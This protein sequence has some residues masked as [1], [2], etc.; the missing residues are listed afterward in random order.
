M[1]QT[2]WWF[3]SAAV[4]TLLIFVLV[5]LWVKMNEYDVEP[6]QLV[7]EAATNEYLKDN[8][9]AP[10]SLASPDAKPT[11]KIKTGIFIQSL[12]FFNSSEV[13]LTGY[14]WQ[15]YTDGI[16]D[17]IKPEKNEVG[18]ILP[19]QVNSGSDI[20]PRE[21]YR[22][23]NGDDEVIGWYFEAT[24]KQPFDYTLYPFDHKT[25]WVRM[26]PKE[27]SQ[28]IVLVPDFES[29]KATGGYDIFGIEENIVLGTWV[30][31]NTYFDYKLSSY[32]TD[33]GIADYIG[34]V[35]FPELHYN[36][37]VKRKFENAFIVYLLPLFLVA[38][39]LFSALLTVSAKEELS[40]TLGFSTSGFIGASS[41]LFFVV[42]LAHIQLREQFAGASI[43]YI[44]Y[45]YVLM[46]GLLVT[47]T[48]NTYLFSINATRWS[49]VISYNDNIIPKVGYWPAV[50]GSLILITWGVWGYEYYL[51]SQ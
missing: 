28:N 30:R 42:M 17:T 4:S 1:K 14:I 48:A 3:L 38:T 16:H 21:V 6:P 50:L 45:F 39:L 43:V 23:R 10:L 27:F 15:R 34:Q 44:E 20:K 32:D 24:L 29:Y 47:A 7:N 2:H 35:G 9:E 36:F 18:F 31:K 46:Y 22:V 41:A 25:V 51:G 26:W 12:Q 11:I 37:V 5:S 8:W 40:S 19:E 49:K 13:H 33:F